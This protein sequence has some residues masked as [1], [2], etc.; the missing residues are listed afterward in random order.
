MKVWL[1]PQIDIGVKID[2]ALRET[3]VET[4]NLC[5]DAFFRVST[6]FFT[7]MS[8]SFAWVGCSGA[9]PN[10]IVG[11]HFVPPNLR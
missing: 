11:L 3:L 8:N 10:I 6:F 1:I 5:R 7:P 9:E 2:Y 4:R